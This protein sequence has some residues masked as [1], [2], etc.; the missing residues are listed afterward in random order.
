M[1]GSHHYILL[2]Q[3]VTFVHSAL[4]MTHS[5][6]PVTDM[7]SIVYFTEDSVILYKKPDLNQKISTMFMKVGNHRCR[8]HHKP[9][10]HTLTYTHTLMRTLSSAHSHLHTSS[11]ISS[12]TQTHSRTNILILAHTHA[13]THTLFHTPS[14]TP[15]HTHTHAHP[16]TIFHTYTH[17]FSR[18]KV[19][20]IIT[21]RV[22]RP[23]PDTCTFPAR[24]ALFLSLWIF[25]RCCGALFVSMTKS[26]V[27]MPEVK[28][29]A[30]VATCSKPARCLL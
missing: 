22:M 13:H 20:H 15:S 9:H 26:L 6:Y 21:K 28:E 12:V 25:I 7:P 29:G 3:E 16:L 14:H 2:L 11:H 30:P 5:R 1:V 4:A 8:A 24:I 23:M 18:L 27:F 17:T 10:T 19:P